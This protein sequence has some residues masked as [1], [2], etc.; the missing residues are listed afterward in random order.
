MSSAPDDRFQLAGAPYPT[1]NKG[2]VPEFGYWQTPVGANNAAAVSYDSN[3][4]EEAVKLLDYGYS[5]EGRML[6]N[7]GIEGESYELTDGYPTYTDTITNNPEGLAMTVAL[8]QYTLAYDSGPFV[9]DKRYMEQY[10]NLPEQ[11]AAW[12]T[13]M[14]TNM[15]EHVLPYLY[16]KEEEVSELANLNNAIDTYADEMI[17]KFIMGEEPLENY[18]AVI[19]QLKARGIDRVLEMRQAAYERYLEK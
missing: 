2:E 4:K 6:F 7:F 15:K 5:E 11:Q 1:K 16:V 17:M 12:N 8:S 10:A 13:W 18:S 3:H 19:E 14:Q 9:Q